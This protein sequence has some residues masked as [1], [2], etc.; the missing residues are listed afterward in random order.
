MPGQL[1]GL[2]LVRPRA[3]LD[4]VR[5]NFVIRWLLARAKIPDIA[6]LLW[7]NLLTAQQAQNQLT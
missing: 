2:D 1:P 3:N 4:I 5:P 6:L 7:P